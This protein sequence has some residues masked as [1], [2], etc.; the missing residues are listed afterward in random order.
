VQSTA[1]NTSSLLH[2]RRV[3]IPR[4]DNLRVPHGEFLLWRHGLD[5]RLDAI[6][7]S[8]PCQCLRC[9]TGRFLVL[10][11]FK[12]SPSAMRPATNL[13]DTTIAKKR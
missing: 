1:A 8:N 3:E 12:K 7:F 6:Q 2:V 11:N 4:R 9:Q 13:V 10:G 5:V